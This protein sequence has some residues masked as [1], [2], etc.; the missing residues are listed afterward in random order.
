MGIKILL[1]ITQRKPEL[2]EACKC[3]NSKPGEASCL[4]LTCMCTMSTISWCSK[5]SNSSQTL[6]E[7]H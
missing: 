6:L 4:T 3:D 2:S 5:M 1:K 7:N